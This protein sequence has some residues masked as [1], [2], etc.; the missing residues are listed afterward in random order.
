VAAARALRGCQGT[1]SD[2]GGGTLTVPVG[3]VTSR[4]PS[5]CAATSTLAGRP[6]RSRMTRRDRSGAA[7]ITLSTARAD[8]WRQRSE[9]VSPACSGSSLRS[10]ATPA[11][12]DGCASRA[13]SRRWIWSARPSGSQA[14]TKASSPPFARH[15][16]GSSERVSRASP[17][18]APSASDAATAAVA[19][20]FIAVR[21][22][23]ANGRS[24]PSRGYRP[25]QCAPSS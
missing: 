4:L 25:A 1:S 3:V 14:R 20:N 12:P 10:R 24:Y 5:V 16:F 19:T 21:V 8:G 17:A 11:S 9:T 15:G 23:P 22:M 6:R 2:A 18:G 7:A 13:P